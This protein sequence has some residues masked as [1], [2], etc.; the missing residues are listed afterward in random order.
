DVALRLKADFAAAYNNRGIAYRG[1]GQNERAIADY[2]KAIERNQLFADAYQNRGE[3]LG[4]QGQLAQGIDDL[5]AAIRIAPD[6]LQ[7]YENRGVFYFKQS[8]FPA[9]T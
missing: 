7:A 8:N 5:S 3:A 4:A 2:S 9:A 6:S 1:L